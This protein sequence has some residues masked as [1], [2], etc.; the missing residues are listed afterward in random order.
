MLSLFKFLLRNNIQRM[1]TYIYGLYI[2]EFFFFV[3]KFK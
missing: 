1:E 3:L 2:V